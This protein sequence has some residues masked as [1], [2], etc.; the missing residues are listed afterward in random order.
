MR[1]AS[2]L[3]EI[4]SRRAG[5][6]L[7]V[8]VVWEPVILTDIA[9][10]STRVLARVGDGRASQ[11]WDPDHRLSEALVAAALAD[12]E[13]WK[14][15]DYEFALD[16]NT[17]VWDAVMLVEAGAVWGEHP[18]AP[19]FSGFPVVD[20]AAGLEAALDAPAPGD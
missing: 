19:R 4:L 10:V 15:G 13:A 5:R 3:E 7:A 20:A 2:A 14:T 18:P 6:P 9:P 11:W 12:K 8:F 1:G 17:L 16:E